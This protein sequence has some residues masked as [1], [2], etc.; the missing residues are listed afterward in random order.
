ME[1]RGMGLGRCRRI[2]MGIA[3]TI[4]GLPPL[5]PPSPTVSP[6]AARTGVYAAVTAG[7]V[8][9]T[10][11]GDPQRVYVPDSGS[12]TVEIIDPAT[13]Q[14]VDRLV[15][16][17]IPHHVTPS[18]DLTHLYVDNE[19][20]N[21]LTVIDPRTARPAGTVPVVH[22]YNLYFTPDGS[23]A[24]D[25]VE[26]FSRLDFL[27]PHSWRLLRSVPIPWRGVD[28]MDFTADGTR[29][30]AS[31][32]FAGVLVEIDVRSMTVT[33]TLRV[34]GY[35]IDV[36]LAPD[37]G[38]FF[39]ANQARNGVSVVDAAALREVAFVP[40][41]RGAHGL[42]LSRD[43]RSFYV[44]NRLEGTVSVLDVDTRRVRA[45]WRVGGSPD[46]MTLSPDGGQ[47]WISGRFDRAVYVLDTASGA[48]LHRI[49]VGSSPH[50]LCFFPNIGSLSLGHNGMYR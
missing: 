16:G 26:R 45:T 34:G 27:D 23:K 32:E 37:G 29:L 6:L 7:E 31:T 13:F 41:G 21:S 12:G 18:W 39:V 1:A 19:G 4:V 49:P 9:P 25:V 44:A 11:V 47:L 14:V 46:M 42:V 22:P 35:P 3:V 5:R 24:I 15:V 8:S 38:T 40:T 30:L 28:H 50:G 33:R 48:L 43:G 36:R 20:F 10:V 17:P 2:A